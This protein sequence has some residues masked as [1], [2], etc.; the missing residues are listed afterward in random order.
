MCM[1]MYIYVCV[2]IYISL[3]IIL[4]LSYNFSNINIAT[5]A[6]LAW[7]MASIYVSIYDFMFKMHL[8]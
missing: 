4:V 7:Y 8:L 5:L 1:K 6:F 2:H 3:I